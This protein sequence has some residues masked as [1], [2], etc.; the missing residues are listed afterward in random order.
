MATKLAVNVEMK[1][2]SGGNRPA[3]PKAGSPRTEAQMYSV[4][5]PDEKPENLNKYTW[6]YCMVFKVGDAKK[7]IK[8]KKSKKEV[9]EQTRFQQTAAATIA[10]LKSGGLE[11][12]FYQSV[13]EDEVY[14]L[15]GAS[16]KR[17]RVEADRLN[18][19]LLL[20]QNC[21]HNYAKQLKLKLAKTLEP[22][23]SVPRPSYIKF[24]GKFESYKPS[25]PERQTLY[26]RYNDDPK[27][28][29][30]LFRTIDRLRLIQ[31]IMASD[32]SLGGCQL[33]INR[34]IKKKTHSLDA[35][36]P[37]HEESK[38]QQLAEDW[39]RYS[40]FFTQPLHRISEYYG[41]KIALYFA[42]LEFYCKWLYILAILGTPLFLYQVAEFRIDTPAM[43][44]YACIVGIWTTIFLEFWK[45]REATLVCEWGMK[46]FHER[47]QPRPE[48][49]GENSTDPVTGHS[50]KTF[51][52][53]KY[54]FLQFK[55]Q[56]YI[57]FTLGLVLLSLVGIFTLRSV[58]AAAAG[59]SVSVV[60]TAILNCVEIGVLNVVGNIMSHKLTDNENHRTP[61]DYENSLIVKNFL[62]KFVNSFSSLF[63][64]AFFKQY[65]DVVDY[66]KPI[67]VKNSKGIAGDYGA[68]LAELQLQLAMLIVFLIVGDNLLEISIPL[69]TRWRSAKENQAVDANKQEIKKTAPE[70]QY[71]L[72]PYESTFEDF[73]ELTQQYGYVILFIVAFPL[74]PLLVLINN[75]IEIRLDASKITKY[76]RR[77]VPMGACSIGTWLDMFSLVSYIAMATNLALTV[78]FSKSIVELAS[79]SDKTLVWVFVISEHLLIFAKV[80]LGYLIPDIPSS[81]SEHYE[82]NDYVVD[83][84]ID[85]RE[86]EADLSDILKR[87]SEATSKQVDF[88]WNDIPKKPQKEYELYYMA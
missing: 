56:V 21:L 51:S 60:V 11:T 7:T 80:G 39:G 69:L 6:D 4:A 48:F 8:L 13:Q 83:L 24:F 86:E 85:G 81:V 61:S 71:D 64:I 52:A 38:K 76:G 18:T 70:E 5:A 55:S 22:N 37:L 31:S 27:H 2:P 23:A 77:P 47:E 16:E 10:S 79:N 58:L 12:T 44:P 57:W 33:R 40:N 17:L 14:C 54:F 28:P 20:D 65:D 30:T 62:F 43:I 63:Y 34:L 82:H 3:S 87:L 35:C 45:R 84:L 9:I 1:D 15:I 75:F 46:N 88:K 41:E 25:H 50:V 73:D 53:L 26:K 59:N 32:E 67:Y 49:R 72:A 66:C 74:G 19:D 42:F 78:F 29:E 68:C 36:F